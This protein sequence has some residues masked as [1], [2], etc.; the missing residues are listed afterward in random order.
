MRAIQEKLFPGFVGTG[1]GGPLLWVALWFG[2]MV[3]SFGQ[4]PL[5]SQHLGMGAG[6]AGGLHLQ[7]GGDVDGDGFRD[8]LVGVPRDSTFAPSNGAVRVFSGRD[9]ALV[10]TLYTPNPAVPIG[11]FLASGGVCNA[12][13]VDG[14]GH[15]DVAAIANGL[16]NV[17]LF[18]FSGATGAVIH[19]TANIISLSLYK[20]DN[21]GDL[22]GDGVD[23][24]AVLIS[25]N[26]TTLLHMYSGA[27]LSI[28]YSIPHVPDFVGNI[29]R[30]V[31]DVDGDGADDMIV[32]GPAY[33]ISAPMIQ[34]TGAVAVLS[35]LDGSVIHALQGPLPTVSSIG[36][37]PSQ[38][39]YAVDGLGDLNGDGL[40]DFAVGAPGDG[41][42]SI[43]IYSGADASLMGTLV[44]TGP[45]D[46]FGGCLSRCGDMDGD[47]T[48]DLAVGISAW[49][50]PPN[51]G[52]HADFGLL[53][54][55]SGTN[56]T[57]LFQVQGQQGQA[58]G[59][60]VMGLGDINN[61]GFP[62][63]GCSIADSSIALN[64]GGVRVYS[65]GGTRRYG[66]GLGGLQTL[67]QTWFP[68]QAG[69]PAQ[70]AIVCNGAPPGALGFFA[71]SLYA[72][73]TSVAGVPVVI[74]DHPLQ[75]V[76]TSFILFDASGSY[77]A[78]APIRYPA[79][80][81]TLVRAQFFSLTPPYASSN[82]LEF[83]L[84]P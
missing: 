5:R 65:F 76:A 67:N 73:N 78:L 58:V 4:L 37:M 52:I 42:G 22:N 3:T 17:T 79:F 81:G 62:D 27:D 53:V 24:L 48:P 28:L 11:Q 72:A 23:E 20:I 68:A 29:L 61:D 83:L 64:N 13:D 6:E 40:S 43:R 2:L 31:G 26:A 18:V 49:D 30:N 21:M 25:D 80:G 16:N 54:I 74:H 12:G 66:E 46:G 7:R 19:S 10:T 35:G 39:G 15:D 9:G 41:S 51:G 14:D 63:V 55:Y 56:F 59:S 32:G 47:G 57:P 33:P 38:F 60:Y 75:L 45:F 36:V 69:D 1:M 34:M 84:L 8:Y 70:G 44:G 71:V 82:G 77:A 50:D